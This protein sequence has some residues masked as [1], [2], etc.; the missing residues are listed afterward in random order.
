MRPS[1]AGCFVI[2]ALAVV[3]LGF[4]PSALAETD[5]CKEERAKCERKCL[6]M[7]MVRHEMNE[8]GARSHLLPLQRL[9]GGQAGNASKWKRPRCLI[10]LPLPVLLQNFKCEDNGKGSQASSCVC[11]SG[12]ATVSNRVH[13]RSSGQGRSSVV[14]SSVVSTGRASTEL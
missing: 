13:V 4:N 3:H 10:P 12:P 2:L 6:N 1:K 9:S 11:T 5:Y 7:T 8:M 14:S